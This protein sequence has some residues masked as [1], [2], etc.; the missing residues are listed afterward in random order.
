MKNSL[1]EEPGLTPRVLLTNEAMFTSN[2]NRGFLLQRLPISEDAHRKI[3]RHIQT[4]F[5]ELKEIRSG[6]LANTELRLWSDIDHSK[7]RRV[8]FSTDNV[9][10]IYGGVGLRTEPPL[11]PFLMVPFPI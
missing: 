3:V 5:P 4:H 10:L 11:V 7:Q 8:E 6:P 9:S 1:P 2:E